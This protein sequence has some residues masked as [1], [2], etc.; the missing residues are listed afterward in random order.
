MKTVRMLIVDDNPKALKMLEDFLTDFTSAHA[1][2]DIVGQARSGM[3]AIQRIGEL[4]PDLV[5]MDIS[6]PEM[7]G[8]ETT[9]RIKAGPSAPR[10]IALTASQGDHVHAAA[11]EAGAD[12]FVSK[13]KIVGFLLP[14]ILRLFPEAKRDRS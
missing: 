1:A 2:F 10:V 11:L 5:L 12:G 6:M 13:W 14:E 8:L 3:E 7:D 4:L 9:R